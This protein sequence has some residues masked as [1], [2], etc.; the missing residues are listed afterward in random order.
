VEKLAAVKGE[1]SGGAMDERYHNRAARFNSTLQLF[2]WG[3]LAALLI[4][5]A[6]IAATYVFDLVVFR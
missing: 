2:R 6:L 3:I 1:Q 4:I 5:A